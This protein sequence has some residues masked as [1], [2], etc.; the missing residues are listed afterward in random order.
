MTDA[1]LDFLFTPKPSAQ[2][3]RFAVAAGIIQNNLDLIGEGRV[4]VRI[5]SRPS[6]EPWARLQVVGGAGS[7]GFMWIPQRGDEVL[8][9]FAENDLSS[10]YVLGGLWSTLKRPPAVVATD[11]LTKKI[12][13]TGLTAA[14]G[15]EI[16]LDDAEQSITITTSTKQRIKLDPTT[17][18]MS[19]VAGTVTVSLDNAT[20]TITLTAAKKIKL[21][22]LSIELKAAKVDISAGTLSVDS[23]GPCIV[24]GKPIKLN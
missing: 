7:R 6:F 21:E 19:N 8:V 11:V 9:A 5:P 18:E 13:K 1:L 17:I 23:K 15:H 2:S 12:I 3:G 10:A 22:S 20:Q 4:Q 16:E 14:L 24:T